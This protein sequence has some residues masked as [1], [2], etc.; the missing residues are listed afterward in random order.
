MNRVFNVLLQ[1][2]F[3]LHMTVELLQNFIN[4]SGKEFNSLL[5]YYIGQNSNFK[6]AYH[7]M[8][9]SFFDLYFVLWKINF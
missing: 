8:L 5:A 7:S 9:K 2:V 1:K 6:L 3:S 4:Y